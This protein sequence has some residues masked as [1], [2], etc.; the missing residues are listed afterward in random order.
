MIETRTRTPKESVLK[1]KP[2]PQQKSQPCFSREEHSRLY[3]K[4]VFTWQ[5]KKKGGGLKR[6]GV[7]KCSRG[8][9]DEVVRGQ[10]L[11]HSPPTAGSLDF[12]LNVRRRSHWWVEVQEGYYLPQNFKNTLAAKGRLDSKHMESGHR[13]TRFYYNHLNKG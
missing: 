2:Q 3:G 1:L 4:N 13:T 5:I 11:F 9:V 10:V 7:T 12:R 6:G 8:E